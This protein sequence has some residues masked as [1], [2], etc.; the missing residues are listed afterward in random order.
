MVRGAAAEVGALLKFRWDHILYTGGPFVAKVVA[1]A[2]AAFLTPVTLELGGKCP[3]VVLPGADLAVTARR[4]LTCK[5][6]NAGQACIAPDYVLVHDDVRHRLVQE[7]ART[8]E[9]WFGSDAS[10]SASFG[11]IVSQHHFRRLMRLVATSGGT[12]LPQLGEPNEQE[13]FMPPTLVLEPRADSPMMQE[14]IF[15]PVLAILPVASLADMIARVNGGEKPLA[16]YVFGTRADAETVIAKT[17][18]GG[19]CVNDTQMQFLNPALPF[20]G[21]GGSGFGRYHGKWGFDEFSHIKAVMRRHA[22]VDPLVRY[23]PY[24]ARGSALLRWL[25]LG[26]CARA[27]EEEKEELQVNPTSSDS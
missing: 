8:L 23:P 24:G 2:A 5:L 17:S 20:G 7:L 26:S 18:S 3:A 12:V 15:G 14:E 25:V 27:Q 16:L 1:Q 19:V 6:F 22:W 21:V 10:K 9:A 4:I 13:R 11:R